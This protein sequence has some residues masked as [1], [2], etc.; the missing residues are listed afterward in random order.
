[1]ANKK[2]FATSTVLT[3]PSPADTGTSLV[4]QAGHGARFPAAPFYVTAHPPSEF[5]TLDNAEKLLV[6]A[7]TTDTFTITRGEADTVPMLIEAGWRISNSI[8]LDDFP[9][10]D[11][12]TVEAAGAVMVADTST[13]GYG[14]VID[15]DNMATNTDLKI[16]TQQSVKA[17]VDAAITATK[18]ALYPIGSIYANYSNSANPATLLGFGTWT[19]MPGRVLV[20]I[21]STQTEFDTINEEGGAKTHTLTI[22]ELPSH[23]HGGITPTGEGRHSHSVNNSVN[24]DAAG[25]GGSGGQ[26]GWGYSNFG[27]NNISRFYADSGTGYGRDPAHQHSIPSQGDGGAHNNL[28]PYV[29][30]YMWRRTA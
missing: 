25:H 12:T 13:A 28:Q 1:M 9:I 5:P 26:G 7:K 17:Y 2:D 23:N 22:T 29:V 19:A 6:T 4:V 20:G 24:G 8:Y 15:E 3:A 27:N 30:V 16:P 18:A 21:D 11:S 10:V 14:F